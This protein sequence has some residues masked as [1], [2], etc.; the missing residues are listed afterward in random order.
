[1]TVGDS[2]ADTSAADTA[3]GTLKIE[4]NDDVPLAVADSATQAL[5]NAAVVIDVLANDHRGA[6]G[7]AANQVTWGS[8]TGHGNLSYDDNGSF[9][10]TPAA[11]EEGTVTF[12]YTIVDGDGDKSTATVT[13]TLQADSTPTIEVVRA[14]GD[15]GIV[16]ESALPDGSGGGDLTASGSLQISTG[17]DTVSFIEVKDK[18]GNWVKIEAD[19]TVVHGAYGD[20]SVNK[21]GTWTYTLSENTT[22]H[23]D[24]TKTGTDDQ[25]QDAFAVRVTD[26]DGDTTDGS[27]QI[28][29]QIN[30]DGPKA[31]NDSASQATENTSV[32][33]DVFGNDKG[34]ADGVDLASG[35]K[36]VEGTL[37]GAGSLSYDD[38]G[39]FTY[40]PGL[41]E[42]GTVT[43][44]Y[45][46]TDG[47][48]DTSTATVTITLQADSKPTVEV[49]M[50]EGDDGVVW[51]SAL[52]GGTGG[53]DLTASGSL[54]INTGNDA[55]GFIEVQDKNGDW[56]KITANNTVVHGAYGDL[57]VNQNGSWTYTL[58]GNTL[59]HDGVSQTGNAD[60]QQDAFAVRVTDSDN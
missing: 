38:N 50:A 20:L 36:V 30:D 54:Q 25:V 59:D 55:L 5:E 60:Q 6:D 49:L 32:T 17:G 42:E 12:Q 52:P 40:T 11:G 29:V 41:G 26:S 24:A 35:I 46:I 21:N 27:A 16:S 48:G 4:F 15:D 31:V 28:T 56:I 47:D 19:G 45:T 8:L 10:Y 57:L 43:F 1:Y 58:A 23:D 33:V 3:T 14:E 13:I 2:D 37:S 7:V 51:E 18:D 22:D 39:S 34:G 44:K 9:T 53:G